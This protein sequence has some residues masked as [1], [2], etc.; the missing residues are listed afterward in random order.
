MN[1]DTI[2]LQCFIAVAETGSFTKAADRVGRTQSAISQQMTKLEGLLG[3]LLLVRGKA[4]TLTPEGEIFLGYARQ[5]FALHREA[6]DRFKEPE[7]EGE[8]RFGLPEN[9]ATVYL[10]DVLADF[11]RIHPRILLKIE[12]DLTLNLFERFKQNEFDLVLVKMNRPE[13]F[14][15]GLDVWSE[16]LKWVGDTNLIDPGKPV[17]LVLAPQPC[18]YRASAIKSLEQSSR[19]WRLV[20][21]SP[22]YAGAVA[23]VRAGMGVSVMPQ[24]MI[25]AD[26]QAIDATLLPKLADTHVSLIKHMA[27]N[28]A[29]N[30][31]EEFVLRRLKH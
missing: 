7:L 20:F 21:S 26:L 1:I 17:P 16:P 3:K 9:F 13:D 14:P 22:S 6:L 30:T 29:I 5:I 28:A 11:S 18:V 23:A 4:F 15:N 12:C 10:S 2:A 31:L 27:N 24:T 19:A 8:V 25:P